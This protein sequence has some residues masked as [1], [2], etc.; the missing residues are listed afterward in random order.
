MRRFFGLPRMAHR[1]ITGSVCCGR[2]SVSGRRANVSG[3]LEWYSWF[4][5][6]GPST[7]SAVGCSLQSD[8]AEESVSAVGRSSFRTALHKK[9][10]INACTDN[11]EPYLTNLRRDSLGLRR[12]LRSDM[13]MTLVRVETLRSTHNGPVGPGNAHPTN[14]LHNVEGSTPATLRPY[15]TT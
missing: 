7:T 14:I 5:R 10:R 8:A 6:E 15:Y 1:K 3:Q 9:V 2:P 11:V 13:R 4:E 12:F